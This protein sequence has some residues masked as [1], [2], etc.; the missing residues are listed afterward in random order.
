MPRPGERRVRQ[1]P[2]Q[3]MQDF[4]VTGSTVR[5]AAL[6]SK[7]TKTCREHHEQETTNCCKLRNTKARAHTPRATELFV[8]LTPSF[9]F[10][11]GHRDSTRRV[12][13]VRENARILVYSLMSLPF[14]IVQ[15]YPCFLPSHDANRPDERPT[16][17]IGI[18][19]DE[20]K[21]LSLMKRRPLKEYLNMTIPRRAR[22]SFKFNHEVRTFL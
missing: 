3:S 4:C 21:D 14:L 17:R 7:G 20:Q 15:F 18:L 13:S 16:L 5:A 6:P 8:S 10:H 2:D 1:G 12:C 22:V 9:A 19:I 11:S